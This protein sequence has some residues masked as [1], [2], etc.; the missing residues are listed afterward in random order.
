[1]LTRPHEVQPLFCYEVTLTSCTQCSVVEVSVA[2]GG[3]AVGEERAIHGEDGQTI[4]GVDPRG[5]P[6]KDL[7][8]MSVV[9]HFISSLPKPLTAIQCLA[10]PGVVAGR[11]VLILVV[12]CMARGRLTFAL[13]ATTC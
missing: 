10:L 8:I 2:G 5:R 12:F 9:V 11:A 13:P 4:R 3:E 1:M 7:R 6:V